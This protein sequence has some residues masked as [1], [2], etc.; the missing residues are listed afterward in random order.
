MITHTYLKS[1]L[2]LFAAATLA[3][4]SAEIDD[5]TIPD[6]PADSMASVQAALVAA[7]C[8][9]QCDVAATG[10]YHACRVVGN[11]AA[12]CLP[13]YVDAFEQCTDTWCGPVGMEPVV[14]STGPTVTVT[15]LDEDPIHRR[16]RGR[17]GEAPGGPAERAGRG[18]RRAGGLTHG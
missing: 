6:A 18:H 10:A 1:V 5:A 8:N 14:P 11:D 16:P 12:A 2:S 17:A 7:G 3:A 15:R 4:C 13:S 9:F